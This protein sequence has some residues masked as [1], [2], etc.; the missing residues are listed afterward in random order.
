MYRSPRTYTKTEDFVRSYIVE[1]KI[2]VRTYLSH[3]NLC[4]SELRG[5]KA[6]NAATNILYLMDLYG[7]SFIRMP[8]HQFDAMCN[9]EGKSVARKLIIRYGKWGEQAYALATRK[10]RHLIE[11]LDVIDVFEEADPK[12]VLIE[13]EDQAWMKAAPEL[14][15]YLSI[16][17]RTLLGRLSTKRQLQLQWDAY[18]A[19]KAMMRYEP[20]V[21]WNRVRIDV[22]SI[23]R[24]YIANLSRLVQE[25]RLNNVQSMNRKR[26]DLRHRSVLGGG[27]S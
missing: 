8:D 16:D 6:I 1:Q 11:N 17:V 13:W 21:M 23:K 20:T 25:A 18:I 4:F 19:T 27:N 14:Y 2:G 22:M 3:H 15:G 26:S 9:G 5:R 10:N 24:V 7:H 12:D